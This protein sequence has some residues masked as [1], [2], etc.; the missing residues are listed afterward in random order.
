MIRLTPH[1]TQALLISLLLVV[2][3]AFDIHLSAGIDRSTWRCL[4]YQC[5]HVNVFHLLANLYCIWVIL[6]SNFRTGIRRWLYAYL[7][8][9]IFV[10]ISLPTEGASGIVFALLGMMSW[11][12]AHISKYHGYTLLAIAIGLLFP[13]NLN[14]LLHLLCYISGIIIEMPYTQWRRA[15]RTYWR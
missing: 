7:L 6:M 14:V 12:S 4:V 2:V 15:L 10:L 11:Q 1:Y 13:R 8:S 9:C 3:F 5:C